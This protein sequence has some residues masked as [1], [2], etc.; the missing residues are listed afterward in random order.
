MHKLLLTSLLIALLLLVA[1]PGTAQDTPQTKLTVAI[2]EFEPMVIQQDDGYSGFTIDLWSE[3]A[4]RM[5]VDYQFIA[6]E[7]SDDQ[8][9]AIA[10][11]D[12]DIALGGIAVTR[13]RE[14]NF[15][16]S[17]P[18]FAAGLRIMIPAEA[19]IDISALITN[20]FSPLVVQILGILLVTVLL[21][22][23]II[24]FVERSNNPDH[25]PV[26]YF[27]G[28]WESIWWAAVTVTTVGYGDRTPRGVIGR[29][30]GLLWMIAG[31]FLL[32]YFTASV[33]STLTLRELRGAIN[34][35]TDLPGKRIVTVQDSTSADY[36]QTRN[37]HP[38][39]VADFETAYTMLNKG[40]ADAV[41]YDSPVVDYYATTE[42]KGFVQ[43]IDKLFDREDYAVATP[44]DSP[45]REAITRA[46]LETIEDGSYN[47]IYQRWF[48]SQN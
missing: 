41:V 18:Y 36:L 40:R 34:D 1:S 25:F 33:T 4:R 5:E 2:K 13:D 22:A 27:A 10:H 12:A 48:D 28:I 17:Y 44:T 14:E 6:V 45:Y 29:I 8:L 39:L 15:D 9:N 31:L 32:T 42:G 7:T 11:S 19:P 24:W 26:S 46:I 38:I 20:F 35:I 43:V 21:A 47:T 37:L 16:F 23:H 3:I 30:F